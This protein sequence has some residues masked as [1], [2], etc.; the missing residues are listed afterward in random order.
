MSGGMPDTAYRWGGGCHH[1]KSMTRARYKSRRHGNHC[2]SHSS[3][4][5][6]RL[7]VAVAKQKA[8]GA[9]ENRESVGPNTTHC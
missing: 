2:I 6:C 9:P 4:C 3:F 1:R 8:A 5:R 7:G